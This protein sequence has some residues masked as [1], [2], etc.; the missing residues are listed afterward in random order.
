MQTD[1][2]TFIDIYLTSLTDPHRHAKDAAKQTVKGIIRG[3][4]RGGDWVG[5]VGFPT[6]SETEML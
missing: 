2:L 3:G 1:L 6:P 4:S 5:F